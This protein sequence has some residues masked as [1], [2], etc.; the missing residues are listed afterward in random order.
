MGPPCV[1]LSL[2]PPLSEAKPPTSLWKGEA[3]L[4]AA[5]LLVRELG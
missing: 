5:S 1:P 2:D 3:Q 4:G